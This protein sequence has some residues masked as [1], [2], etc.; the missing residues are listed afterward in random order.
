MGENL[1]GR[2][3]SIGKPKFDIPKSPS[4]FKVSDSSQK[5]IDSQK[6]ELEK[7]LD[8]TKERILMKYHPAE[9]LEE[10]ETQSEQLTGR[11][12]TSV[13]NSKLNITQS[14]HEQL[15]KNLILKKIKSV[16]YST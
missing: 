14:N 10:E 12:M 11:D 13:L 7:V 8:Q 6:K 5:S 15:W 9:I 16:F 1:I 3:R 4:M 2:D